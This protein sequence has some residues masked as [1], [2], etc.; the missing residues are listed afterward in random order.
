NC[1]AALGQ[2]SH[3]TALILF[4]EPAIADHVRDQN[5][6]KAAFHCNYPTDMEPLAILGCR[7]SDCESAVGHER[8]GGLAHKWSAY[9]RKAA[10]TRNAATTAVRNPTWT[11][12]SMSSHARV[13]ALR[14]TLRGRGPDWHWSDSR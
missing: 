11:P 9:R 12:A 10:L 6:G 14:P 8:P 3:R 1:L 13:G 4:H 5:G 2:R 7:R